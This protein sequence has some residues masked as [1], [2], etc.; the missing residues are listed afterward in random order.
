M[1][2]AAA[3]GTRGPGGCDLIELR[4]LIGGCPRREAMVR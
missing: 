4:R 3:A 2:I 1:Y